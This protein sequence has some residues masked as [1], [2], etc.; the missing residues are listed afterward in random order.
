M[1]DQPKYDGGSLQDLVDAANNSVKMTLSNGRGLRDF[2]ESID[3]LEDSEQELIVEQ[4]IR[5]AL[6]FPKPI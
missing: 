3:R 5:P 2:L 1:G 6:P 4:A